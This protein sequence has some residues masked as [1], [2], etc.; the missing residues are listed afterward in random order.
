VS[1]SGRTLA[2]RSSKRVSLVT[3]ANRAWGSHSSRNCVPAV[4]EPATRVS[5]T[6]TASTPGVIPVK[7]DVTD[8]SS[9]AVVAKL[10]GDVTLL[11]NKAGISGANAGA[12]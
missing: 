10:Y 1:A 9:L 4:R 8:P 12:P 2:S 11:I 7:L 3:G 5:G 6:S